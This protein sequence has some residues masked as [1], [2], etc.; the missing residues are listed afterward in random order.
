MT[1]VHPHQTRTQA[2]SPRQ[3][4][5]SLAELEHIRLT[6]HLSAVISLLAVAANGGVLWST[7]LVTF[8]AMALTAEHYNRI[9]RR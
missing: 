6:A 8:L 9:Q 2:G 7:L 4:V 3:I 5:R 1:L